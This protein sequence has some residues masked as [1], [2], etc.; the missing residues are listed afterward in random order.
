MHEVGRLLARRVHIQCRQNTI[1]PLAFGLLPPFHVN[2]KSTEHSHLAE[3][4]I[5]ERISDAA[6]KVVDV[7]TSIAHRVIG[8]RVQDGEE[9]HLRFC[10]GRKLGKGFG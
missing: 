3:T 2:F 4:S 10:R 9:R 8:D 6:A 1:A 7:T 5:V